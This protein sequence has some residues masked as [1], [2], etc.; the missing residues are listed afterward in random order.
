MLVTGLKNL[1]LEKLLH[2]YPHFFCAC[3]SEFEWGSLYGL[4]K[5]RMQI[6]NN[7]LCY[8]ATLTRKMKNSKHLYLKSK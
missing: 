3:D 7:S 4:Q 2:L 5:K 1:H 6:N 8:Q